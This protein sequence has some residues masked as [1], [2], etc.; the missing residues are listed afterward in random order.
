MRCHNHLVVVFIMI[1]LGHFS[2]LR[3]Q[4][5]GQASEENKSTQISRDKTYSG[6]Q[7]LEWEKIQT[8][9]GAMKGKLDAQMNLVEALIADKQKITDETSITK[10]QDLKKEHLKLQKMIEDYN[11]LNL[12]FLTKYPERGVKEIRVYNRVKSKGLRAYEKNETIA[13]R[14][15]RLHHKVLA[16]YSKESTKNKKL[17]SPGSTNE[18]EGRQ[19]ND[20]SDVTDQITFEK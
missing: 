4:E 3:A 17:S 11:Q 13:E 8:K 7:S 19:K 10:M 15:Q 18:T 6:K 9:L 2:Q 16:Q 14:A 12:E 5:K 1:I 20:K